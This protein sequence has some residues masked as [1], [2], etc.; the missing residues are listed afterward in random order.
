[1]DKIK[2]IIILAIVTLTV[3]FLLPS[4]AAKGVTTK[5]ENPPTEV[6]Q[7]NVEVKKTSA[8]IRKE[9]GIPM[10]LVRTES[11]DQLE[12]LMKKCKA[13]KVK[14]KKSYPDTSSINYD[15]YKRI[16]DKEL[17]RL[18]K[19]YKYYKIKYKR[20]VHFDA[21]AEEYPV[22]T[23]I[24]LYLRKCG[25]NNYVCAGIMGNIMA[26]CGG[27]SFDIQ[28]NLY[29]GSYYGICQWSKR[30]Y[31]S[32]WGQDLDYQ[33]KYLKK[34]MPDEFKNYGYKYY[35]GFGYKSFCALE[36]EQSAAL[37][38]AKCYERCASAYYN[39]RTINATKAYKYFAW[40]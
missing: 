1:M 39:I 31:S 36:N 29:D 8:E 23:K 24:W 19:M 6:Y 3:I 25:F 16:I 15:K 34:T 37:A 22:A 2:T 33:L 35:R 30:W 12:K 4:C 13:Q 38:F 14:L 11:K 9:L 26:E 28:A 40:N 32:V 21:C 10:R 18:D 20:A 17:P 7:Q 27:Q 5:Q